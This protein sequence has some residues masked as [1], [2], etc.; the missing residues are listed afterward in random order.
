MEGF[1]NGGGVARDGSNGFSIWDELIIFMEQCLSYSVYVSLSMLFVFLRS[2][3][4]NRNNKNIMI[5]YSGAAIYIKPW[6]NSPLINFMIASVTTT[7]THQHKQQVDHGSGGRGVQ[8]LQQQ[9]YTYTSHL[10]CS[11]RFFS[12]SISSRFHSLW[13]VYHQMLRNTK[14][15]I[16]TIRCTLYLVAMLVYYYDCCRCTATLLKTWSSSIVETTCSS[17]IQYDCCD[18]HKVQYR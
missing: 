9:S 1:D 16:C 12:I 3:P 13:D 15:C 8:V 5:N 4:N 2:T 14:R 6:V 17:F 11:S 10:N 7:T 18:A